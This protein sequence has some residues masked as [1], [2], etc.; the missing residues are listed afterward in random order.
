MLKLV[1]AGVILAAIVAAGAYFLLPAAGALPDDAALPAEAAAPAEAGGMVRIGDLNVTGFPG[2]ALRKALATRIGGY[3][4]CVVDHAAAGAKARRVVVRAVVAPSGKVTTASS[5][6]G[7]ELGACL[8]D[9]TRDI[10]FPSFE[11][12]PVEISVPLEIPAS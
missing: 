2:M 3:H 6:G 4:R 9:R 12:E 10:R 1:A 11:G 8:A 7:G 5:D